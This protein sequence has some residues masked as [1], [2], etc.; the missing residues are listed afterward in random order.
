MSRVKERYKDKVDFQ[1]LNVDL[2]ET[3]EKADKYRIRAIP[4]FVFINKSGEVTDTF[5]GVIKETFL[6]KKIEELF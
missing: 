6:V 2:N 4:T 1:F 3:R 5:V